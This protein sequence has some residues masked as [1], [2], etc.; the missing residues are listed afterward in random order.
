MMK[1]CSA[2][3]LRQDRRHL[4]TRFQQV[5]GLLALAGAL[6]GCASLAEERLRFTQG[7]HPGRIV[8]ID[9][10]AAISVRNARDCRAQVPGAADGSRYALVKYVQSPSRY[11]YRVAPI[12]KS[13][14]LAINDRV[15]VNLHRCDLPMSRL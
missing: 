10:A 12:P 3:I 7:W 8:Q 15:E 1:R 6:P 4:S 14:L 2:V 5:L 13:S 11:A 9:V